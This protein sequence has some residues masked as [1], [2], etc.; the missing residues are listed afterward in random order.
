M[1][2]KKLLITLLV[3]AVPAVSS[4]ATFYVV[5]NSGQDLKVEVDSNRLPT[6]DVNR[7]YKGIMKNG[8]SQFI[9]AG[10]ASWVRVIWQKQGASDA[11]Y[12]YVPLSKMDRL[13]LN[14]K[15]EINPGGTSAQQ[16]LT[17][18]PAKIDKFQWNTFK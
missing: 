3:A 6:S 5:N 7:E 2:I 12:I 13:K 18:N 17:S 10:L 9:Q 8:A 1:S 15:I 14:K 11:P 16:N 4:A